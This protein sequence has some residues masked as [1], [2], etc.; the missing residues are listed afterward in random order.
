MGV[1]VTISDNLS[2]Y[3]FLSGHMELAGFTFG[4]I[5]PS[6][7]C[8]KAFECCDG[9]PGFKPAS[10]SSVLQPPAGLLRMSEY[11][12]VMET[13]MLSSCDEFR[14]VFRARVGGEK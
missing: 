2:L 10:W 12:V 11:Q 4:N 14:M 1:S 7:R 9:M 8:I 6:F 5:T 3:L 13:D